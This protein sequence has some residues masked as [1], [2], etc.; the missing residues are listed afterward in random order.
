MVS[1]SRVGLPKR[2]VFLL[3]FNPLITTLKKIIV[4]GGMNQDPLDRLIVP[5]KTH[6]AINHP[7]NAA[8]I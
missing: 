5:G 8:V 2:K 4:N 7:K 3:P 6:H 1:S